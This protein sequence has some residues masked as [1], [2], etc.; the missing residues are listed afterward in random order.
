MFS[1][2]AICSLAVAVLQLAVVASAQQEW[3]QVLGGVGAD[4][5]MASAVHIAT[6]TVYTVAEV[7]SS[8][9]GEPHAGARDLAVIAHSV[10]G[11]R[12]WVR[13][14]GGASNELSGGI[15]VHQSTGDVVAVGYTSNNA[16]TSI[17][18]TG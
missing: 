9:D 6:G 13:L 3:T 7:S 12:Q 18:N 5:G 1:R 11:V 8:I 16:G 17:G 14:V 15:A 10:S 4:R 2:F